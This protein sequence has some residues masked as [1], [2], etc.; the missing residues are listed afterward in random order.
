MS[1][2][3][4]LIEDDIWERNHR[5]AREAESAPLYLRSFVDALPTGTVGG[6]H[7]DRATYIDSLMR[8]TAASGHGAGERGGVPE[9]VWYNITFERRLD[10]KPQPKGRRLNSRQGPHGD[11]LDEDDHFSGAESDEDEEYVVFSWGVQ[12]PAGGMKDLLRS[13]GTEWGVKAVRARDWALEELAI[14]PKGDV[15]KEAIGEW[16]EA[17]RGGASRDERCRIVR[18]TVLEP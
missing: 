9:G 5:L 6:V 3:L 1:G 14:D 10:S 17:V 8:S 13:T 15:C 18:V 2:G 12:I 11:G 16:W 4:G 7:G